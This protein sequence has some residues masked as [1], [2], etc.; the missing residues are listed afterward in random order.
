VDEDDKDVEPGQEGEVLLL[1]PVVFK[2]YHNNPEANKDAF[3]AQGWFKTGDVGVFKDGLFY[4][5]DRKKVS[6]ASHS[7]H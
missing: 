4:I 1:G 3:D 7:P 5:V 6:L 2:G